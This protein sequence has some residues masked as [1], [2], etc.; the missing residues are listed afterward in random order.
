MGAGRVRLR[1]HGMGRGMS[2]F[3][4][5]QREA[6]D[7]YLLQD[8][9]RFRAWFWLI[10][11]ACWKPTKVRIKGKTIELQRGEM[12]FSQRFLALKWG[13]SKS[14]VERFM[15]DLRDEG[16]IKTRQKNGA[17]SGATAGRGESII[18]ICNYNKYQMTDDDDRGNS[19]AQNGTT[20]RQQRGNSGAKKNK[21][22]REQK[23]DSPNGELSVS[24]NSDPDLPL[25]NGFG[26]QLA[27]PADDPDEFTVA[28]FVESWNETAALCGLPPILKL[29]AVRKRAFRCRQRE[30]PN[31]DDW[32]TAFRCLRDNRWMHGENDRG[33]RADPD[34][35][36]QAKSFT[37]LVEGS[38]GKTD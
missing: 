10:A 32:R 18:S 21:G 31:I 20:A 33:W 28:D 8:G 12:V 35:F 17:Q 7:H 14:R 36:L 2:G 5:M 25:L 38:H 26:E 22:T 4:A 19:G 6:L 9:E 29:T 24:E 13:W 27:P 34:F 23:K 16:M 30:F 1:H 11:N 15:S 3:I 37:K